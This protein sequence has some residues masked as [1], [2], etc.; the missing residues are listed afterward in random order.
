MFERTRRRLWA[1]LAACLGGAAGN[2][3]ALPPE[4]TR[5]T[6]SFADRVAAVRAR[7]SADSAA[8]APRADHG[9]GRDSTKVAQNWKKWRNE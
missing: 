9:T 1:L 3:A 5:D 2:A 8:A 6:Q 4:T 7:M